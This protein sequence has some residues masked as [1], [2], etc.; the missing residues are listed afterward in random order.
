MCV[1]CAHSR[2][3]SCALFFYSLFFRSTFV[4]LLRE[5]FWAQCLPS[6][7]AGKMG[8]KISRQAGRQSSVNSIHLTPSSGQGAF[9]FSFLFK[10][11]FNYVFVLWFCESMRLL[12]LAWI[13]T[14]HCKYDT[15]NHDADL[16]YYTTL[17]QYLV[18]QTVARRCFSIFYSDTAH[19]KVADFRYRK[20]MLS[21]GKKKK[22]LRKRVEM[23]MRIVVTIL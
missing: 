10:V 3:F 14:C 6:S 4:R 18:L 8:G 21:W 23:Y 17:Y 13:C 5:G 16:V 1:R 2:R 22:E 15:W 9:G 20:N 12:Q 7:R 11:C 19:R